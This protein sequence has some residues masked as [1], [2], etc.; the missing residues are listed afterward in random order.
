MKNKQK[1]WAAVRLGA[2][3]AVGVTLLVV[4][5]RWLESLPSICLWR[6]LFGVN[7]PGCG[8]TRA[9]SHLAHL[10]FEMAWRSNMFVFIVA[11][12][13]A[14][15]VLRQIWKDIKTLTGKDDAKLKQ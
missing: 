1:L 14:A 2:V 10:D 8:M 6:R 4:P 15:V 12:I 13:L 3:A 5:E 7:C 9:M 11:P